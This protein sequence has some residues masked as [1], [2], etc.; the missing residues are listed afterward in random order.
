[1]DCK[2][3]ATIMLR[4]M[5]GLIEQLDQSQYTQPLE[6]LNGVALGQHFRHIIDF[7]ECLSRGITRQRVDY[8]SRK[9]EGQLESDPQ[10]ACQVL[11][12]LE[13]EVVHWEADQ[14]LRV[15]GD[16][17]PE[18]GAERQ[19][20]I[21]SLGRELMYVHDHALH[22]LAIVRIALRAAFP[23]VTLDPRVGLAP[24]TIKHQKAQMANDG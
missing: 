21:S 17:S 20:L 2:Q 11:R 10:A 13:E 16:F 24:A 8:A 12:Q 5:I 9:R 23:E 18:S 15:M 1:M 4:Q 19:A 14:P 7:F 22:H 6:L 3:G